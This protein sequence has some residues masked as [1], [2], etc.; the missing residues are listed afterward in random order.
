MDKV[1]IH[2]MG[3]RGSLEIEA[4]ETDEEDEFLGNLDT[5][6]DQRNGA[7]KLIN[8]NARS[9]CPKINS[10]VDC[11]EEMGAAVGTVTETWLS[12]GESLD[13]D[14]QNFVHGT[15]LNMLCRNRVRNDRGFSHGGVALIFDTSACKFKVMEYPNPE[16][17]EVLPCVGSIPGHSRKM[18]IISCYLPPGYD[19]PRGKSCLE[20]ISDLCWPARPNIR[21]LI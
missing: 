14:I 8:T 20:Y 16:D 15:G 19:V 4:E 1:G 6:N 10:L 2:N 18:V 12:D 17:Y 9:L 13:E 11:F 7:F 5:K 3:M 21:N